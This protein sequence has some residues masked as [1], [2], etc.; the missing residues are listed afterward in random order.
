LENCRRYQ[1]PAVAF[2]KWLNKLGMRKMQEIFSIRS[3]ATQK[4]H[5]YSGWR[6]QLHVRGSVGNGET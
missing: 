5:P 6:K 2:D 1:Q 3:N 4:A